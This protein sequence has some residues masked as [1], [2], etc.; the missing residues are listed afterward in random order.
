MHTC[1]RHRRTWRPRQEPRPPPS[2]PH[3]RRDLV[4][5]LSPRESSWAC[6]GATG[7]G[8]CG[9]RVRQAVHLLGEG[10][11]KIPQRV[12]DVVV[13]DVLRHCSTLHVGSSQIGEVAL[14]RTDDLYALS[15]MRCGLAGRTV[16]A[17]AYRTTPARSYDSIVHENAEPATARGPAP[18]GAARAVRPPP[19]TAPG[20]RRPERPRRGRRRQTRAHRAVDENVTILSFLTD[21]IR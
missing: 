19:A 15:T 1:S 20:A 11:R 3:K 18:G 7:K 13:S 12:S 6:E 8:C 10:A 4:S 5:R 21:E 14:R 9:Q 2:P 16:G 17:L